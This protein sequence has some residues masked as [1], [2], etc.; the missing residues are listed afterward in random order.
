MKPLVAA[1]TTM[2]LFAQSAAIVTTDL[3]PT[4]QGVRIEMSPGARPALDPALPTKP[5]VTKPAEA[6]PASALGNDG[7]VRLVKAGLGESAI[8]GLISS[9]PGKYAVDVES[10]LALKQAGVPDGVITAMASAGPLP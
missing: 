10:V 9:Q 7:I 4:N 2:S 3:R 1:M 8:L 6:K 5:V